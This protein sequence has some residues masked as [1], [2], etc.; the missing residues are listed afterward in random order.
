MFLCNAGCLLCFS[1]FVGLFIGFCNGLFS[2]VC[3]RLLVCFVSVCSRPTFYSF[4]HK[5]WIIS[6]ILQYTYSNVFPVVFSYWLLFCWKV[7]IAPQVDLV[8]LIMQSSSEICSW[9]LLGSVSW[10]TFVLDYKEDTLC[11]WM[12]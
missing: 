5:K 3:Y 6:I 1:F 7:C 8:R 4:C 9:C 10:L 2:T 11:Y 12:I